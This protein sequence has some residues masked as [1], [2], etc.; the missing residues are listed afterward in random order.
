[1]TLASD[2]SSSHLPGNTKQILVDSGKGFLINGSFTRG[3]ASAWKLMGQTMEA[4]T[5]I[6]WDPG[7]CLAHQGDER[8]FAD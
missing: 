6:E 2:T 1:M 4:V 3:L 7:Q 8:V 5:N